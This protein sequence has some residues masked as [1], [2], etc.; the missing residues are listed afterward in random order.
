MEQTKVIWKVEAKQATQVV[1]LL[2]RQ[3][4]IKHINW[5]CK[6]YLKVLE[7]SK[8]KYLPYSAVCATTMLYT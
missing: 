1:E 6:A 3:T 2:I 4:N 5:I 8:Q 7:R